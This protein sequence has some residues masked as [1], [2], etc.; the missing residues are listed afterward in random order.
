MKYLTMTFK[1]KSQNVSVSGNLM[2]HVTSAN[3]SDFI[4]HLS[5]IA[6]LKKP[7]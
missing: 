6:Y 4:K 3:S 7:F 2:F 5:L 1:V